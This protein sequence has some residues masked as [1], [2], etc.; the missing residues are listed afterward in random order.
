[1]CK[2]SQKECEGMTDI[3]L[4]GAGGCMREIIW[5]LQEQKKEKPIWN[6]A[7]YVD[8]REPEHGTGIVVGEQQITYLGNDDFLLKKTEP[9][10]VVICVGSPV[11]RKR[12]AERLAANAN[13]YFPNLILGNTQICDDVKMG[14]GCIISMDAR[15]STNVNMG[16]FVFINIGS[17]VCHDGCLEDFV[18]LS[19]D[20][21][22]AGGVRV[23]AGSDLGM[24]SKVIQGIRIGEN[25]IAGA[26]S[27]VVQDVEDG[28]TIVGV[29]A[30]RIR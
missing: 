27:V 24:G 14:I 22:L 20:V 18:T 26:G 11:L 10:N 15:I 1:M 19:P 7:G 4:A 2:M 12:I 28:C 9:V 5:Q 29:P 21:K 23:G 6:V 17:M 25:V 3:I 13:I 16:N 30:R 8:C